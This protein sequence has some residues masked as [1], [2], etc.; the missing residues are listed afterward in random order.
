MPKRVDQGPTVFTQWRVQQRRGHF[1]TSRYRQI[2]HIFGN[3][4]QEAQHSLRQGETLLQ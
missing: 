2:S 4:T 1:T 3:I